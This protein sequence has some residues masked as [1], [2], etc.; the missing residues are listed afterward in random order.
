MTGMLGTVDRPQEFAALVES[1]DAY[2]GTPLL[3]IDQSESG[4]ASNYPGHRVVKGEYLMGAPSAHRTVL[5]LVETPYFALLEDDFLATPETDYDALIDQM[6]AWPGDDLDIVG[7][8]LLRPTG[9]MQSIGCALE[10][11]DRTLHTRRFEPQAGSM[12]Y[13]DYIT[14]HYAARTQA[15]IDAGS[16]DTNLQT[17]GH[18]DFYLTMQQAGVRVGL[19][20]DCPVIHN[21]C[22]HDTPRYQM[23]RSGHMR[24][25][26]LKLLDKWGLD[27]VRGHENFSRDSL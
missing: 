2:V 14:N 11:K 6:T 25:S 15:V 17:C 12:L 27:A 18:L 24:E 21:K 19:T 9:A 22:N 16:W 10:R 26:R 13:A 20:A 4:Y 7:G 3:V 5:H 8:A 1:W 23:T